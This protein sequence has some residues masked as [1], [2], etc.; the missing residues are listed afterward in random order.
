MPLL[1]TACPAPAPTCRDD[2]RERYYGRRDDRRDNRR[3]DRRPDDR[4]A[5]LPATCCWLYVML[6]KLLMRLTSQV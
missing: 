5:W 6:C 2:R 1:A 4:C 3:D